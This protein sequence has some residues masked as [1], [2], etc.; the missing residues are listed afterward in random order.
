[1]F[2]VYQFI[3]H[4]L[5]VE[6]SPK[7]G[8]ALLRPTVMSSPRPPPPKKTQPHIS[9]QMPS[10]NYRNPVTFTYFLRDNQLLPAGRRVHGDN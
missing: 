4:R 10:V 6:T 5:L 2:R 1:M 7:H 9:E 8:W 3:L